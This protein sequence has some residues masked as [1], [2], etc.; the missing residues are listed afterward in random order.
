MSPELLF[1]LLLAAA[2]QAAQS[3]TV[4]GVVVDSSSGEPVADARIE[5]L[6]GE[7]I[8]GRVFSGPN[9]R[10]TLLLAPGRYSLLARRIGYDVR[11]IEGVEVSSGQTAELRVVL[12][13]RPV[14][15]SAEVVTASRTQEAALE[16]PASV[17]VVVPEEAAHRIALTA[18]DH[19]KA[20]PGID[21][22]SSGLTQHNV[23]ARGFNNAGSGQLLTLTDYR[24]ASV[25]ALRINAY[26][27]IPLLDE[28]IDRI[29]VVRGPGAALY[30]PNTTAGVLHL[31]TRSPFESQGTSVAVAVGERDL[32]QIAARHAGIIGGRLGWKLSGQY[33]RAR[34]WE[35]VDPV[36]Q[37]NRLTALARGAGPSSLLIGKRDFGIERAF[38]EARVEWRP[39]GKTALTGNFGI[40]QAIKNIDITGF[41]AAQVRNWR[42]TYYQLRLE[43][44]AL[45]AQ[46]FLNTSD[47]GE[48][49]LL[50][51]GIP[52]SDRSRLLVAQVHHES[53][54]GSRHHLTYGFDYQRTDPR[55]GGTIYGRYEDQ[56]ITDELGGY[57]HAESRISKLR[58][59]GAIRADY[60]S[61][62]KSP[63]ISPRL[64]VVAEPGAGQT[65]RFT[66]NRA[67]STPT[68]Y[69]FFLDLLVDSLREPF[70]GSALPFAVRA[71]G[72][73]KEG[74]AFRRDCPGGLANL[75][76]YSPFTPTSLGGSGQPLPAD[77]TVL[78]DVLLDTLRRRD[79]SIPA[80]PKPAPGEVR[81]VL[82][83]LNTGT[84]TFDPLDPDSLGD[85]APLEHRITNTL[86]LGYKG[87]LS[88]RALA[89]VDLYYSWIRGFLAQGVATPNVFFDPVTL[90]SYLSRFMPSSQATQLAG[91]IGSIPVATVSPEHSGSQTDILV[92][93]RNFGRVSY[94]GAD[95]SVA[96][97]PT[98]YTQLSAT[99]SWASKSLFRNVGGISDIALNAPQHKIGFSAAYAN[100]RTGLSAELKGRYVDA[101]PVI[102]GVFEG[103]VEAYLVVDAAFSYTAP[104]AKG[105]TLSLDVRNLLD[106]R[107]REFVNVPEIG[108]LAV[109]RARFEF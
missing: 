65:V 60:H 66:Y 102:S 97:Q 27:F 109:A 17:S 86:E 94:W 91:I 74:M 79:P 80:I 59:V 57:L 36:E 76:M 48:T 104:F 100:R 39:D 90:G 9:G 107:H 10:F 41:G 88:N 98:G 42:Y 78:W 99:Y 45:F 58:L 16:A 72:V 35:Y 52:V 101:F 40:N 69:D 89:A 96:L 5:A 62:V 95:L 25:P 23:V 6:A 7:R 44:D 22:V 92:V 71:L 34:D 29:E 81:S 53:R 105:L 64:G 47:A 73:P 85:V 20:V 67:F 93:T 68:T 43:R 83:I 24:Y 50:R 18:V 49:Y 103:R 75:C 63:V 46:V 82:R 54:L 11:R 28:D 2:G 4:S 87:M 19:L 31:I 21:I 38:G 77:A 37:Q 32:F 108:R 12:V 15:V 1:A 106:N 13:A 55:T 30:G 3:G 8:A 84:R 61:R 33:F 56:D 51:T 14:L 26:N 70:T